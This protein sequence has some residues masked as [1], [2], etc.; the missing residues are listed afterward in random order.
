M[1]GKHLRR[2]KWTGLL[3]AVSLLALVLAVGI[4]VAYMFKI[5]D[6]IK[7]E[8]EKAVVTCAVN[9]AFNS[10][11]GVKSSITVQNTGNIDA[12][13]RV[14]LVSYWVNPSGDIIAKQSTIPSFT[15]AS[16]WTH[17]G[18]N[19]YQYETAIA[20]E[21]STPNLLGSSITL[22]ETDEDGNRQVIEVFAEA[23]Q[24]NAE[25]AW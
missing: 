16:G 15:L 6:P 14:R 7:N 19:I 18:N 12:Y 13:I 10:G 23:I 2:S 25:D 8:F 1:R 17:K 9:E 22:A 5:T 20:P 21:N 24:T 4:T 11:T 3:R